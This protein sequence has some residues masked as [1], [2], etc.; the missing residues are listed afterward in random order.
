[1]NILFIQGEKR[2]QKRVWTKSWTKTHASQ[3]CAQWCLPQEAIYNYIHHMRPKTK[4]LDLHKILGKKK[5]FSQMVVSWWF[6]MIVSKKSPDS[7]ES[8]VCPLIS[9]IFRQRDSKTSSIRSCQ[10]K[11]PI[12][13]SSTILARFATGRWLRVDCILQSEQKKNKETAAEMCFHH[14]KCWQVYCNI[15]PLTKVAL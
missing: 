1:M 9:F 8:E 6:P 13:A 14:M 10:A 11:L 15:F 3:F 12:G 7:V 5:Q 2:F 4:V